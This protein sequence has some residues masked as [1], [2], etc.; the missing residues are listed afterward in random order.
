[1]GIPSRLRAIDTAFATLLCNTCLPGLVFHYSGHSHPQLLGCHLCRT[2]S[3]FVLETVRVNL[4]EGQIASLAWAW[5]HG[6]VF[7]TAALFLLGM[8]IGRRGLFQK[9]NLKVWNKILA[10][11]LIAFFP[12][13]GLGNMLPAFIVNKSILTPLSLIITS[14]SNFSFMLVLVSGVIFAF[15]NT[16]MHYL[17]MKITPYGKMSL[18]NYITQSIVGSMLY[19]NW[20]FALHNQ[21]GITV[22]CLAGIAFFIL[23]FTFC[24]WWMSHHSHGPME[25]IWKRATWLK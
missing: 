5:D 20:G 22:S 7:Q 4:W 12:L 25:Y 11:A 24:R 18:T 14:L 15:Y 21:C 19:Y 10:G 3:W 9:E 16:N 1:M 17:L 23:Q 13:Y 8:L 2:K 6:R